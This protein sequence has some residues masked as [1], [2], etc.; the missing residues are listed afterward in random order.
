M[1]CE[2]MDSTQY[3]VDTGH[4]N[5]KAEQWEKDGFSINRTSSFR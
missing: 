4:E 2:G 1:G 5:G 3:T